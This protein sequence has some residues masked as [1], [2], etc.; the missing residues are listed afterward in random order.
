MYDEVMANNKLEYP[1][2][3]LPTYLNT[4]PVVTGPLELWYSSVQSITRADG[5]EK[6]GGTA[7]V[8][9]YVGDIPVDPASIKE[10]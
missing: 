4:P 1:D 7:E 8:I 6:T 5:K 2:P 10:A 9:Y 3:R